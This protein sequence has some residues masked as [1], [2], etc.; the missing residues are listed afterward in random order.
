M[1]WKLLFISGRIGLP[2]NVANY[3][4]SE[5]LLIHHLSDLVSHFLVHANYDTRPLFDRSK[6]PN[7]V[8]ISCD[9][10]KD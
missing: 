7:H 5:W 9:P 2:V 10:T 8:G 4:G 3:F 1:I 6:Q